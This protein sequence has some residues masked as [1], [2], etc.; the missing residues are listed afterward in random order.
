MPDK[1]AA[2]LSAT[3]IAGGSTR[4]AF[5]GETPKLFLGGGTSVPASWR[6]KGTLALS[7]NEMV[8]GAA[9]AAMMREEGLFQQPGDVL[10]DFFGL[11]TMRIVGILEPTGTL[12][13]N[14]HVVNPATLARLTDPGRGAGYRRRRRAQALLWRAGRIMSRRP[15]EIGCKRIR[16]TRRRSA[17][18]PMCP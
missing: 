12:L 11:P 5:A 9:E 14:Y 13:D 17:G 2:G 18:G 10:K 3:L 8:L 1:S 16:S 6:R 4:V 15:C 7:D